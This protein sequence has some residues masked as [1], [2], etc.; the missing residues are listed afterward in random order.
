MEHTAP[1]LLT[2]YVPPPEPLPE[3]LAVRWA[4]GQPL[5]AWFD[6]GD[7]FPELE[8]E[9]GM[10]SS[11]FP[12]G[13]DP[14]HALARTFVVQHL[15][16]PDA[17][18]LAWADPFVGTAGRVMIAELVSR[19]VTAVEASAGAAIRLYARADGRIYWREKASGST[20]YTIRRVD[21]AVGF[22]ETVVAFS[23]N[24]GGS[25][26]EAWHRDHFVAPSGSNMA[27]CALDT[28]V[29]T[30]MARLGTGATPPLP[31][32][33]PPSAEYDPLPGIGSSAGGGA[34]IR[35]KTSLLGRD[36]TGALPGGADPFQLRGG[37]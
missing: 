30:T 6:G 12:A 7:P 28:A 27:I 20:V 9:H 16:W 4:D 25:T 19:T 37:G 5:K 21:P 24:G 22:P 3:F 33:A 13:T 29:V 11:P 2:V 34:P 32:T 36:R 31:A 35:R 15:A 18:Y 8:P 1:D 10:A 14:G 17:L 26:L 23:T